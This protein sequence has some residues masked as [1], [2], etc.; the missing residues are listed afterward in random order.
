[1]DNISTK[2]R[3]VI[4][5]PNHSVLFKNYKSHFDPECIKHIIDYKRILRLRIFIKPSFLYN[6]KIAEM[7]K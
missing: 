2:Y 6:Q 7:A 1:M 3:D 5:K 4:S